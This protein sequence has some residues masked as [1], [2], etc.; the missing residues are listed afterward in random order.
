MPPV[1]RKFYA[2]G[3]WLLGRCHELGRG[4]DKARD[5]A[6]QL[7]HYLGPL[8]VVVVGVVVVGVVVVVVGVVV[9]V[10]AATSTLPWTIS[11]GAFLSSLCHPSCRLTCPA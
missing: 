11:H 1:E 5:E 4:A 3:C 9:V 10:V 6:R 7:Q 2:L 8:V